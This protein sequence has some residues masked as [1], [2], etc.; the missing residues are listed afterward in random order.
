MLQLGL[1]KV[2][3]WPGSRFKETK[4]SGSKFICTHPNLRDVLQSYAQ[5]T[6]H[7]VSKRIWGIMTLPF[8]MVQKPKVYLQRQS[9]SFFV[10]SFLLSK[11]HSD[12]FSTLL[13]LTF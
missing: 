3:T 9:F 2:V 1:L 6:T 10:I 7:L 12:L 5:L 11:V 4:D 8:M 13:S